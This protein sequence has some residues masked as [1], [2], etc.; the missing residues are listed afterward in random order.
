METQR[1]VYSA[2]EVAEYFICKAR[3]EES[4]ADNGEVKKIS[5]L[6]LQKILYYAQ[7][8]Y[9]GI[10]GKPLF[11]EDIYAW[12]YGPVVKEIYQKYKS[13]GDQ[14]L[15]AIPTIKC[16]KDKISNEDIAKHLD[17]VWN[18]YKKDTARKLVDRTHGSKP[19]LIA[20]KQPFSDIIEKDVMTAY[21]A[22]RL[23]A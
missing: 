8:W 1:P 11:Q 18:T 10:H 21:F 4:Q 6:K 19:W 17:K 7:G 22:E 2:E 15:A 13:F 20:Y 23:K 14:N 3:E 12:Q 5:P 9:L 16:T